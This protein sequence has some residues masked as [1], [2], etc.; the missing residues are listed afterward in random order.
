MLLHSIT[1]KP[2]YHCSVY[3]L[4]CFYSSTRL[5][6]QRCNPQRVNLLTSCAYLRNGPDGPL[7]NLL[8]CS[9]E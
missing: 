2:L 3:A 6:W 9:Q 7:M 4:T 5:G 8:V 1:Q